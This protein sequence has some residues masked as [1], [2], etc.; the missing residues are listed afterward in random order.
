MARAAGIEGHLR[1][2]DPLAAVR[3]DVVASNPWFRIHD[4]PDKSL[5]DLADR[6]LRHNPDIR[7]LA[8]VG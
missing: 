3:V 8:Q 5:D 6:A 7:V 4:K 2:G 1:G